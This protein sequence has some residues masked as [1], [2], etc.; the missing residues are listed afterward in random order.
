M[1][2]I[3]LVNLPA[4]TEVYLNTNVKVGTPRYPNLTLAT[5][6]A[7]VDWPHQFKAL[8]LDFSLN[9]I[10]DIDEAMDKFHPDFVCISILTVTVDSAVAVARH[11]KDKYTETQIIC[12]GVHVSTFRKFASLRGYFVYRQ[13]DCRRCGGGDGRYFPKMWC[14]GMVRNIKNYL[15]NA[16]EYGILS[17]KKEKQCYVSKDKDLQEQGRQ[18]QALSIPGSNQ[19]DRRPYQADNHG[20]FG[21]IRGCRQDSPGYGGEDCS[22]QQE[23]KSNQ[24]LQGYAK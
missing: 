15:T 18:P 10:K 2:R 19:E 23:A 13:F 14:Y 20:Q 4:V 22:I 11:I 7:N 1:A 8:D 17:L 16:D 5:I 3:L 21:E 6:A 12:G 24:S 9:L